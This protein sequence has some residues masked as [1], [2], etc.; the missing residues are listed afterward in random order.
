MQ[1]LMNLT[2]H[3]LPHWCP[4][5]SYVLIV[6]QECTYTII[7]RCNPSITTYTYRI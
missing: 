4:K 1:A 5:T 6:M 7:C 2:L 3:V